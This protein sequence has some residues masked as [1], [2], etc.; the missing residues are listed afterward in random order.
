VN[1][2]GVFVVGNLKK[3]GGKTIRA[4]LRDMLRPTEGQAD[5]PG[6]R[7]H[8]VISPAAAQKLRAMLRSKNPAIQRMLN[9]PVPSGKSFVISEDGRIMGTVDTRTQVVGNPSLDMAIHANA[10]R[11][12][13]RNYDRSAGGQI[14]FGGTTHQVHGTELHSPLTFDLNG[15][16]NVSTTNVA[17]GRMFE[18]A[19]G[20]KQTAW[21]GAG[22]GILAFGSGA[23]GSKVLGDN[24]V[25]DGKTYANGF[26]ALAALAQKHL[27]ADRVAKGYL[28][29]ADL[30]ELQ[31][32]A[33]LHMKVA[34]QSAS[35]DRNARPVEDLGIT[36]I[37]LNYAHAGAAADLQG[38]EHRQQSAFVMNGQA[39]RVNDVWYAGA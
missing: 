15:D 27:G 1:G 20:V 30:K 5:R 3:F 32:K 19:P 31:A 33:G 29:A 7:T 18:M 6:E 39:R 17:N 11:G 22:D 12:L 34:G 13:G 28:D 23:D 16:G 9:T 14:S 8:S 21:A 26:E 25:I 2:P 24:A 4:G 37:N 35:Q 36:R 10:P 38:N